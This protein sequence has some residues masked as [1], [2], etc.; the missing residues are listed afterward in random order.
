M[1]YHYFIDI[2]IN[3]LK[4]EDASD[5][6]LLTP[7]PHNQTP[8]PMERGPMFNPLQDTPLEMTPTPTLDNINCEDGLKAFMNIVN[9]SSKMMNDGEFRKYIFYC[10]RIRLTTVRVQLRRTKLL[11]RWNCHILC[12]RLPSYPLILF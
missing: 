10:K 7:S 4:D 8:D 1:Y 2:N 3:F 9:S 12:T 5:C 6:P 11:K